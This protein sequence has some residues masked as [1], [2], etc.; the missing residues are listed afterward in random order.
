[1]FLKR[2][3]VELPHQSSKACRLARPLNCRKEKD[4][5]FTFVIKKWDLHPNT[6][7]GKWLLLPLHWYLVFVICSHYCYDIRALS[8]YM[9]S[10]CDKYEVKANRPQTP[11]HLALKSV[12]LYLITGS[13]TD[14]PTALIPGVMESESEDDV[15]TSVCPSVWAEGT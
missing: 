11:L 6:L 8:T 12:S 14:R 1:M 10:V 2:S 15:D 3:A 4:T 13:N 9:W 5:P 7:S